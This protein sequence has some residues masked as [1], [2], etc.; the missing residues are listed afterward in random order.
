M[1]C[2]SLTI[3]WS[4]ALAAKVAATKDKLKKQTAT[5]LRIFPSQLL[6][7]AVKLPCITCH[8]Q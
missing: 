5:L 7:E 6:P 8:P 2:L 1:S 3:L 4:C